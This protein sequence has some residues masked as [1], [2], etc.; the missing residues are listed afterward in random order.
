MIVN[1]EKAEKICSFYVSDFHLEMILLPYINNK[2]DNNENIEL[3]TQKNLDETIEI[4]LD[5]M[6]LK[7]E[8]KQ[9][10][11][12]LG[13]KT[14]TELQIKDNSNIIVVGTQEYIKDTNSKIRELNL[15]NK[16]IVDCYNFEDIKENIDNIIND[17]DESL[18]TLGHNKF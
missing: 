11:L 3:I 5:K 6:N 4:V 1:S 18:N 13:W 8:N 14:T 17:Y 7:E 12:N 15:T 9:K 10:I 2:I 16:S